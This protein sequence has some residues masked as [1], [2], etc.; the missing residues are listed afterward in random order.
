MSIVYTK[1]LIYCAK[2]IFKL[3]EQNIR[4]VNKC[5]FLDF[6]ITLR[7]GHCNYSPQVPKNIPTPLLRTSS[8]LTL[9]LGYDILIT[10][11]VPVNH[12]HLDTTEYREVIH[13]KFKDYMFGDT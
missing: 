6:I 9:K 12:K 11:L 10:V 3:S 4:E 5:D 2:Q 7:G 8:S 1:K 13:S